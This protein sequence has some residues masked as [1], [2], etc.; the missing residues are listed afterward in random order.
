[1]RANPMPSAPSK[2][3][4]FG[5]GRWP[6]SRPARISSCCI[7]WTRRGAIWWSRSRRHYGEGRGTFALRSPVRPNPIAMSVV[8][9]VALE[10][11]TLSV[12]GL[13]CLDNTPLIDLKPYFASTDA[14]PDAKV[15]WH[16]GRD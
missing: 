7:G 3:T 4:R 15:G 5:G 12:I 8:R 10:G 1:M 9:L 14:I 2:S 13:D 11:T 6:G 16:E